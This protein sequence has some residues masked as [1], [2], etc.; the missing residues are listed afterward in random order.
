MPVSPDAI[1]QGGTDMLI[2]PA[3]GPITR[4]LSKRGASPENVSLPAPALALVVIPAITN[5]QEE[6]SSVWAVD[7]QE[8]ALVVPWN[9]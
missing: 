7:V 3:V 9:V 2:L 6:K 4:K 1:T 5:D 8:T